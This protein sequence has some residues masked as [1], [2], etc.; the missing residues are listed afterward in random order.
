M[1]TYLSHKYGL[2]PLIIEWAAMIVSSCRVYMDDPEIMLFAKMLKNECEENFR[3]VQW[4]VKHEMI[5][6]TRAVYEERFVEKNVKHTLSM[7]LEHMVTTQHDQHLFS[8]SQIWDL[9]VTWFDNAD[10]NKIETIMM[11][12]HGKTWDRSKSPSRPGMRVR[13]NLR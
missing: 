4:W 8:K 3:H 2:K 7:E 5:K 1:Y 12:R 10:S 11:E 6:Q 13:S 9:L